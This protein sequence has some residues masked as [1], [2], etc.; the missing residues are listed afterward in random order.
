MVE[1]DIDKVDTNLISGALY[2]GCFEINRHN[3]KHHQVA[4]MMRNGDRFGEGF[5]T[6]E[7]A[8]AQVSRI[9]RK[10]H[11]YHKGLGAA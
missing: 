10:L 6:K 7:Q 5:A 8:M 9:T 2:L 3:P 11:Q 1:F 4:Y